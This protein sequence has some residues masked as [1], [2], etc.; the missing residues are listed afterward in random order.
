LQALAAQLGGQVISG[1]AF[2][3][4]FAN[5]SSALP[6]L[7]P[8]AHFTRRSTATASAGAAGQPL[9]SNQQLNSPHLP[10][11]NTGNLNTAA[12]QRVSTTNK[13]L[14]LCIRSGPDT[15]VLG[16]MDI[17]RT[18][19]DQTVFRAIKH[20]YEASRVVARLFGRFAYRIPSGGVSVKFRKDKLATPS[21]AATVS[22]MARSSMP[23]ADDAR[24]YHYVFDP[25]PMD[26]PPIDT[27]TFNH[28]FHKPHLAD[29][30]ENWT[31]RFPQLHGVSFFWGHEKLAK[32]WGIEITEDRNWMVLVGANLVALLMS[33]A[34]AGISAY[35]LKD[36][37]TGVAIGAWL[38][39]VQTL[40][41]TALFWRW[42]G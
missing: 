11:A 34:L 38:T 33:G 32:G 10:A 30:S 8:Q 40:A 5:T 9:G 1:P 23:E 31:K 18:Q 24:D 27:H 21:N 4:N 3:R 25:I 37:A 36:N 28:Y 12:T 6:Q 16:E 29:P 22:I 14:E 15:F 35:C 20:K 7:P 39:T 2:Q 42:T 19:A 41:I 17:S 26:Q 13:W